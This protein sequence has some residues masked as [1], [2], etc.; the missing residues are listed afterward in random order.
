MDWNTALSGHTRADDDHGDFVEVGVLRARG[1]S[2]VMSG[3]ESPEYLDWEF[4]DGPCRVFLAYREP[5]AQER[6]RHP[7][8]ARV[9][10]AVAVVP[11]RLTPEQVAASPTHDG[12]FDS[13]YLGPLSALYSEL[14]D[15]RVPGPVLFGD[16]KT[17]PG[18]YARRTAEIHAELRRLEAEGVAAPVVEFI[19]DA[20]TD[21]NGFVFPVAGQDCSTT[22]LGGEFTPDGEVDFVIWAGFIIVD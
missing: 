15:V 22:V 9:V 13:N 10:A 19:G 21:A 12:A 5:T 6:A 1:G 3:V 14:P 11:E 8:F 16:A 4:A 20:G 17:D 2:V 7:D 18:G